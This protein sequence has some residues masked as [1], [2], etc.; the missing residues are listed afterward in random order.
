M[1]ASDVCW[2]LSP[3]TREPF[4][5]LLGMTARQANLFVLATLL[6]S[7]YTGGLFSRAHG[8]LSAMT[9]RVQRH[10]YLG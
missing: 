6:S 2:E 9:G 5:R 10:P 8:M 3:V 1:V 7:E 4:C